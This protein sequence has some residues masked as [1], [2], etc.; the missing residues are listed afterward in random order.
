MG[1]INKAIVSA[2]KSAT[3]LGIS[4]PNTKIINVIMIVTYA[5]PSD[6]KK[7]MRILVAIADAK[8]FT[9]LFAKRI[10]HINFSLL[11]KIFS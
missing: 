1:E 11:E 10:V 5:I 7:S 9:K 2:L 4:S 6:L 3:V 8:T